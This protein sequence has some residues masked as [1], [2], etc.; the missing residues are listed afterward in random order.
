MPF[1]SSFL[2]L[3]LLTGSAF[4]ADAKIAFTVVPQAQRAA[5]LKPVG[6]KVARFLDASPEFNDNLLEPSALARCAAATSPERCIRDAMAWGAQRV[7]SALAQNGLDAL[8]VIQTNADAKNLGGTAHRIDRN[9]D[10]KSVLFSLIPL[11][12]DGS[13]G[14]KFTLASGEQYLL[15]GNVATRLGLA[16][17]EQHVKVK[18]HERELEGN[19]IIK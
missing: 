7:S 19:G 9:G 2:A 16:D 18:D 15:R 5:E 14:Q 6:Q 17:A 12:A 10:L 3:L 11:N 4:A 13:A 8:I 1:K